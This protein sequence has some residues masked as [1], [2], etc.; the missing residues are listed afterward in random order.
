M[1]RKTVLI[2]KKIDEV[3][4]I[5]ETEEYKKADQLLKRVNKMKE[6]I[7]KHCQDNDLTKMSG[8][9]G[10][11]EFKLRSSNRVDASL[12]DPEILEEVTIQ[13]ISWLS[14]FSKN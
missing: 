10:K 8:T 6:D 14:F 9:T 13:S 1:E 11:V 2:K 4:N 3:S 12:L 5:L 7:K